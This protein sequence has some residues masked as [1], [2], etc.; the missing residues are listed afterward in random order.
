MHSL[1]MQRMHWLQLCAGIE[2]FYR[3]SLVFRDDLSHKDLS[4]KE[5][6]ANSSLF[7]PVMQVF[8]N[9]GAT[10]LNDYVV[11]IQRFDKIFPTRLVTAI[12]RI[13]TRD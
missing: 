10:S 8:V 12:Q 6:R 5:R 11:A 3:S 7:G 4:G 1:I 13:C 2:P 9:Q